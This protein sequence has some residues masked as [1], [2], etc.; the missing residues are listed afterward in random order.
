MYNFLLTMRTHIG[1][2]L[3]LNLVLKLVKLTKRRH[4]LE[5]M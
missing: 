3:I 2:R 5:K 1:M 4:L